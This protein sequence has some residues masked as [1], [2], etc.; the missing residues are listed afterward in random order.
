MF[1]ILYSVTSNSYE[2]FTLINP[3]FK[4]SHIEVTPAN[5]CDKLTLSAVDSPSLALSMETDRLFSNILTLLSTDCGFMAG[6]S[7]MSSRGGGGRGF[8]PGEIPGS[9]GEGR[10]SGLGGWIWGSEF[11]IGSCIP[12]L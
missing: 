9:P 6:S 12:G 2:V 8:E 11:I 4:Q 5:L 3:P 10:V 7:S 1:F